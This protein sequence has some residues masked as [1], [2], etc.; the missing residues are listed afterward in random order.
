MDAREIE[1]HGSEKEKK[2]ER[3]MV[4]IECLT[5]DVRSECLGNRGHMTI[6]RIY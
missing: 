3:K 4:R 2:D 5:D 6:E 1:K